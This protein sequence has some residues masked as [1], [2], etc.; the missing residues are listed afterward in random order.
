MDK[1][2]RNKPK[3]NPI[4][5]LK[6]IKNGDIGQVTYYFED[7]TR[8]KSNINKEMF[9]NDNGTPTSLTSI[10]NVF[11]DTMSDRRAIDFEISV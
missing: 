9:K 3:Q 10:L 6:S 1:K 8:Q 7:G 11:K 2:L 4:Q 5:V